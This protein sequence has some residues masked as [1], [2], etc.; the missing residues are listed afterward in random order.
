[1]GCGIDAGFEAVL[2]VPEDGA[3]GTVSGGTGITTLGP[4]LIKVQK[5]DGD[6]TPV[7]NAKIRLFAGGGSAAPFP[8]GAGF[9]YMFTDDNLTVVAGDGFQWNTQTDD[10]GVVTLFLAGVTVGC[11]AATA[12]IEGFLGVE[13]VISAD[14]ATWTLP[15]T[16]DC[17]P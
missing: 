16:I 8:V 11:G 5:A 14:A 4:V 9:S 12:D 7:P 6:P 13:A 10:E 15:F 1:M 2:N 17:T 3:G